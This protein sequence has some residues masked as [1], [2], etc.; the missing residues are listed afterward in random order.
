MTLKPKAV[1]MDADGLR[2]AINRI[3]F[4]IVEKNKGADDLILIGIK[5]RG[6]VIAHRIARKIG[7][8]E[9]TAPPCFELDVT[10]YRDDIP[11]AG[12]S[13]IK[14]AFDAGIDIEGKKVI[15]IDDVLF[16]GRTA[17]A[18]INAVLDIGRAKAIQLAAIVDRGHREL[19]IRP[20]YVGKNIPTSRTE[21]V[22]VRLPDFDGE[23]GVFLMDMAD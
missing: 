10:P 22:E 11:R 8:I 2:R 14:T 3:S 19:P 15:I 16:T 9:E 13:S 7:E 20:D 12:R 17:R 6:A 4:E 5:R 18:A 1:V 21:L 23:T